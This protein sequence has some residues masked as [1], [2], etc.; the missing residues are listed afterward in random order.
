MRVLAILLA[1]AALVALSCVSARVRGETDGYCVIRGRV[2][3][4]A[5]GET[6][7]GARIYASG[8]QPVAETDEHGEYRIVKTTPGR[9]TLSAEYLGYERQTK[10]VRGVR[11]QMSTTDFALETR[12]IR[13]R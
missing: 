3:D 10:W 12:V 6:L 1:A 8:A 13:H 4:A 9:F 2:V 5:S 11:G 7:I